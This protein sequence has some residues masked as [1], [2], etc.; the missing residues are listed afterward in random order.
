VGDSG[1]KH[2]MTV[3]PNVYINL[4]TSRVYRIYESAVQACGGTSGL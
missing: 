3:L 2:T 1:K 4:E